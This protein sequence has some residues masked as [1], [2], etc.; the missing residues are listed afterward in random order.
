M[1][2]AFAALRRVNA[3]TLPSCKIDLAQGRIPDF[4]PDG[5]AR[6]QGLKFVHDKAPLH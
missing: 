5:E 3:S 6:F 4:S 1:A 2:A